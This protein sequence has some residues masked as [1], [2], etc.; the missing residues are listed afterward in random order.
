M[1]RR[2]K[3]KRKRGKEVGREEEKEERGKRHRGKEKNR[4]KDECHIQKMVLF[5]PM[6]CMQERSVTTKI[7]P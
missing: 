4:E 3:E 2:K 5:S 6:K 1:T 7:K